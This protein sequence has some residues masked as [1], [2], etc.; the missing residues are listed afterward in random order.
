MSTYSA[1]A[2]LEGNPANPNC[3]VG[4]YGQVNSTYVYFAVFKSTLD[5][6]FSTSGQAGI[7]NYLTPLMN[8]V[9]TA[10]YGCSGA[11]I[12]LKSPIPIPQPTNPLY[13]NAPGSW[14][15]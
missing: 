9:S 5:S 4:I 10:L 7:Q 14:T 15:A 8:S 2:I 12:T 6:A 13:A 3:H 1:T 11:N